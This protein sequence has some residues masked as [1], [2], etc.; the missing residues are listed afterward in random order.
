[1]FFENPNITETTNSSKNQQDII[2]QH[3][4]LEHSKF[5]KQHIHFL[6]IFTA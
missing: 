1:M 2:T 6:G 5:S 4:N 3:Y